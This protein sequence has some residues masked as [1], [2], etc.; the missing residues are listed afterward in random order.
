MRRTNQTP[1]VQQAIF[2]RAVDFTI[3]IWKKKICQNNPWSSPK[4]K[5][6]GCS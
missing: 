4:D 2:G 6:S 5:N 1:A 3:L